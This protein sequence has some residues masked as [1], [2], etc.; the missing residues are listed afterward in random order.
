LLEK[1][2][3][4]NELGLSHVQFIE[5]QRTSNLKTGLGYDST[6][7]IPS[8]SNLTVY[9]STSDEEFISLDDN[10][11]SDEEY[12]SP[13]P[14]EY[15]TDKSYNA[16]PNPPGSFQPP[17]KDVSC[18]GVDNLEFRKKLQGQSNS[19]SLEE[20]IEAPRANVTKFSKQ[21]VSSN[22]FQS[23]VDHSAVPPRKYF[24]NTDNFR[25]P[26][27]KGF[28]NSGP[29]VC[30][31][32]YSPHHLIKD[33]SF[34]SEYLSKYQKTRSS[35][36]SNRENKPRDNKPVWNNTNRVNHN[37]FSKNYRYPHQKRP[38]SKPKVP[39][40][41]TDSS[42]RPRR[43]NYYQPKRPYYTRKDAR[44]QNPTPKVTTKWVKKESTP[45]EEPVLSE[46]KGEKG[47]IDH[48]KPTVLEAKTVIL[49][50]VFKDSGDYI[51]KEFEYVI[52]QGE[53]KSVMAW[54][55]KRN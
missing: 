54:V 46:V 48:N 28:E 36:Q 27:G 43:F 53:H 30:Y 33:C 45:G 14:L 47:N 39:S 3:V 34:H 29:K 31:V 18:Y 37:N 11:S 25:K 21:A 41:S 51:L 1:L 5:K 6:E 38:F 50:H 10:T 32:C 8:K 24:Q 49:D 12:P 22:T 20:S 13:T 2:A 26:F 9:T 7:G 17:R 23:T 35:N 19:K 42:V 15:K 16:V 4:W 55:P 52:P 40:Q 44:T